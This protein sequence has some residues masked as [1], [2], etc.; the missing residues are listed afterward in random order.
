MT[1]KHQPTMLPARREKEKPAAP[2]ALDRQRLD[3]IAGIAEDAVR[4]LRRTCAAALRIG[5]RLLTLYQN[6]TDSFGAV[7]DKLGS[8][9]IPRSTAQ[10]WMNAAAAV[11]MK[12]QGSGTDDLVIPAWDQADATWLAA[13]KLMETTA[14]TT[15]IRRLL[16]GP[17]STGSD[18]TRLDELIDRTEAGDRHAE[19][20]LDKVA[21]GHLTLVQ[22]IRAASGAAATKDKARKDPVY[23]DIDGMTGQPTGLFPRCLIT[24]SNTFARWE[25][26]DET[27]RQAA[28]A[29]WKALVANLPRDLR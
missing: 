2:A 19:A 6:G 9:Q 16:L 5:L 12:A 13:E 21:A 7:L 18:E 11:L 14:Q 10:R 25:E 17:A 28:K 22:A 1:A 23:L 29:S 20:M 8:L 3:E 24:L 27:A 15:S 4:N 26:I